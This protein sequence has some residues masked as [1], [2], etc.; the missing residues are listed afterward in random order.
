MD[1]DAPLFVFEADFN[2]GVLDAPEDG[3]T[4]EAGPADWVADTVELAA[5]LDGAMGTGGG[6]GFLVID[7]WVSK[8]NFPPFSCNDCTFG[9]NSK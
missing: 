4:A 8:A 7:N 6:A 3:T 2:E 9:I 1:A 5:G